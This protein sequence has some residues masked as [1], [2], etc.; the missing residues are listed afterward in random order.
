MP[1]AYFKANGCEPDVKEYRRSE[2][3]LALGLAKWADRGN[4]RSK[5]VLFNSFIG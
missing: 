4:E 2:L 1:G 5:V 3:D